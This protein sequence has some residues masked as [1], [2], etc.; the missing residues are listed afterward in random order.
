[1]YWCITTLVVWVYNE[2]EFFFAD[3]PNPNTS[4]SK[5]IDLIRP[6]H[7]WAE[8]AISVHQHAENEHCETFKKLVHKHASLDGLIQDN[9]CG[10]RVL[11]L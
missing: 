10:I 6:V 8:I 2:K 7:E 5:I 1:M 9:K 3:I 11:L 4:L